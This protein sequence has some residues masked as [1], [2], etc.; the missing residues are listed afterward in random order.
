MNE[1]TGAVPN[2]MVLLHLRGEGGDVERGMVVL[3]QSGTDGGGVQD[4]Q[5]R[6]TL[7]VNDA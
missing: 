6:G 5:N 2:N 3:E 7:F 1:P 4:G